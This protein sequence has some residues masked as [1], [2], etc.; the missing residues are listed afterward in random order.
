MLFLIS[1][2]NISHRE[3]LRPTNSNCCVY[4]AHISF[5]K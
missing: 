1:T 5:F 2:L 4:L 3:V